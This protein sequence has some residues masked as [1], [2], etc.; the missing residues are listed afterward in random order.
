LI[1]RFAWRSSR[2]GVPVPHTV[3]G[4]AFAIFASWNRRIKAAA[5]W[6]CSNVNCRHPRR[7]SPIRQIHLR[8][9]ASQAVFARHLN[10]TTGLVSKWERGEKHPCGASLKLLTKKGLQAV[11]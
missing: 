1:R 3:T 7:G 2:C 9:K 10:V 8:K 11:P 5:T 6:L 4:G